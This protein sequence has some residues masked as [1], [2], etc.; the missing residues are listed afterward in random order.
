MGNIY[1]ESQLT[2]ANGL[3]ILIDGTLRRVPLAKIDVETPFYTGQ[4][5]A[6][7]VKNPIYDLIIGNIEGAT[8]LAESTNGNKCKTASEGKQASVRKMT[9]QNISVKL[10]H[11][12]P[13]KVDDGVSQAIKGQVGV[14]DHTVCATE[15]G[16]AKSCGR[17]KWRDKKIHCPIHCQYGKD[18]FSG[19]AGFL[20]R[21]DVCYHQD[22]KDERARL[23][24]LVRAMVYSH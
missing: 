12:E 19:S 20:S 21:R 9:G 8:K 5:K 10:N 7:C 13:R 22:K 18:N 11:R 6:L 15:D 14:Q 2:G 17:Y 1:R 23:L 24:K 16:L 4:V 3:M